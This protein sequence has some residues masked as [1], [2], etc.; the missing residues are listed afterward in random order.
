MF[1]K[2]GQS[3]SRLSLFIQQLF[4][5]AK[6]PICGLFCLRDMMTRSFDLLLKQ[7]KLLLQTGDFLSQ[8]VFCLSYFMAALLER[9]L[10]VSKTAQF[11]RQFRTDLAL[12]NQC[13]TCFLYG[14]LSSVE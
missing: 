11:R 6:N 10:F 12:L 14:R 9:L 1:A 5:F 8:D 7:R 13:S 2:I 3:F 4:A